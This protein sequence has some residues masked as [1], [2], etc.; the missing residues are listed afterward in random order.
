MRSA[1]EVKDDLL[2]SYYFAV[3]VR[4][5]QPCK[6][7]CWAYVDGGVVNMPMR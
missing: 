3:I 6:T 1:M 7:A 5:P 4:I 2:Q